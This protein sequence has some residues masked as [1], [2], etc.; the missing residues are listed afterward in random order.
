MN[1][2]EQQLAREL[3][4]FCRGVK[5]EEGSKARE[6]AE[7]AGR[8]DGEAMEAM[9]MARRVA[10]PSRTKGAREGR[11]RWQQNYMEAGSCKNKRL[12]VK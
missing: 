7:E 4:L 6:R 12:R 9:M 10:E 2:D 5:A 3:A 1:C 8:R 11:E